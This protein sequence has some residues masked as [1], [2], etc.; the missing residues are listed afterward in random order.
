[1]RQHDQRP[2]GPLLFSLMICL[3]VAG[4]GVVYRSPAVTSGVNEASKVRVVPITSESVLL[5]NRS[6]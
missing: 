3:M 4:C 2:R 1:M 5:A 6:S